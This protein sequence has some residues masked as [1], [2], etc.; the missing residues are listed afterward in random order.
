[1]LSG[2]TILFMFEFGIE[3]HT[4]RAEGDH[5]YPYITEEEPGEFSFLFR[6]AFSFFF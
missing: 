6:F 2:L 5:S 4:K 1:M 3:L